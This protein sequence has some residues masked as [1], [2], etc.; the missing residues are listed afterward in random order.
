MTETQHQFSREEAQWVCEA[1]GRFKRLYERVNKQTVYVPADNLYGPMVMHVL[2]EARAAIPD[3]F[4][5]LELPRDV[6]GGC[7]RCSVAASLAG[8]A[9]ADVDQVVRLPATAE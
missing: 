4:A 9:L 8:A 3:D 1:L 5:R 7:V 6:A 2:Q